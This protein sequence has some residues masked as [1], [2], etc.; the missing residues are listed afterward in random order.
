M[1]TKPTSA[2]KMSEEVKFDRRRFLGAAA[3]ESREGQ[4]GVIDFRMKIFLS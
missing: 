4:A 1:T 3:K 2:D